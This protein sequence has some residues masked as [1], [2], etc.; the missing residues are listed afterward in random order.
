M[1]KSIAWSK[2]SLS[3]KILFT[4]LGL[5]V[6]SMGVLGYVS[7]NSI[8]ELGNYALETSA[9]LG[10]SAIEDSVAHL[11]RMGEEIITQ[12]AQ[13]VAKQVEMYLKTR[14]AMT[15]EDMR[16]DMA[17]REIAVQPVG[18]TGYTTLIDPDNNIIIIHKFPGQEKDIS[19]L[20]DKL[21]SFWA[22]IES[23][24]GGRASVG[25][26]DWQEVDGSI[27]QKYASVIPI[28]N[29]GE[30][31]LTLWATTYIEEF[32]APAEETKKD[33]STA[34][35][36]SSDY[37]NSN[38][39]GLQKAFFIIFIV[40]VIVVTGLALLLSRTITSPIL[41]LK[42]GAEQIGKGKLDY[43]LEIK[44][45]DELGKLANTFNKMGSSLKHYMEELENTAAENIAKE[46]KI[47]ENLRLYAQKVSQA[48]EDERKRIARELHDETV[49]SLVV[50]SRYLEDLSSGNSELSAEDIREEVRRILEG[51]RRFS[52]ELRPSILD[53]LGLIP[54]VKWL[55]SDLAKNYGIMVD[56]EIKGEQ[57]Q[58]PPEAELMLFRIIQEA[59]ANVRR[60]SQATRASV[61]VDFLEQSIKI[62]IRDNGRGFTMPTPVGDLARIDKLGLAGMHER[63]QLLGGTLSI[64]S[65]INKGTCLTIEAPL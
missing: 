56:S 47:Q 53:D 17:L 21:P 45:Q 39:S 49:Q 37:I 28:N 42:R 10:E 50:V 31:T 40:L 32:S 38:V 16:N 54:A 64:E 61:R 51:V 19:P 44:S 52:Q 58:L 65:E 46:R 57:R 29:S 30:E 15:A 34:I 62:T 36:E 55:A 26:Y 7:I 22:I 6:L 11:N 9:S 3:T 2:L 63:A 60:H 48:Q 25:Y 18:T 33:I 24:A 13:D 12:K 43:K 20:K 59:L 4:F 5:S 1:R 35:A 41:A 14:P 8:R 23:S 27:G